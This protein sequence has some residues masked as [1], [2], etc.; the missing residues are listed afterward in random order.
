MGVLVTKNFILE[1]NWVKGN[2]VKGAELKSKFIYKGSFKNNK[3]H[4]DGKCKW[5]NG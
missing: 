2:I 3:K 4:G 5:V 1:G